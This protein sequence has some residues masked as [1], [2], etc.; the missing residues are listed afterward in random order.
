MGARK[1]THEGNIREV[2]NVPKA[3]IGKDGKPTQDSLNKI[4]AF[5]SSKVGQNKTV[6]A[7]YR[8]DADAQQ[9]ESFVRAR[10]SDEDRL[11]YA[12]TSNNCTVFTFEALKAGEKPLK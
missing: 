3:I 8:P 2:K 10:A 11:P 6:I 9:V 1:S 12:I 7:D 4:Y 5:L